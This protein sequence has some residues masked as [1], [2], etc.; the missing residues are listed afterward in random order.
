MQSINVCVS[1]NAKINYLL[2]SKLANINSVPGMIILAYRLTHHGLSN[3][4]HT[5]VYQH[6]KHTC[7]RVSQSFK[8]N[9][10]YEQQNHKQL[11]YLMRV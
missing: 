4:K 2:L 5:T 10:T 6:C 3:F 1:C 7:E 8:D 9:H 11:F